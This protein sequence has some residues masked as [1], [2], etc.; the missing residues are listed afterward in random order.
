MEQCKHFFQDNTGKY[1][2]AQ[3]PNVPLIMIIVSLLISVFMPYESFR[4]F[5]QFLLECSIFLWSYLEIRYGESPFRH[6]LGGIV[7][8]GLIAWRVTQL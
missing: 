8:L 1:I 7:M 5:G 3:P 4:A 2:I 6:V